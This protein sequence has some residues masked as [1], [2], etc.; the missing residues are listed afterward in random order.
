MSLPSFRMNHVPKKKS[1]YC[2]STCIFHSNNL[3]KRKLSESTNSY[4]DEIYNYTC[5]NNILTI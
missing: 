1:F 3:E 2:L 4:L 5:I